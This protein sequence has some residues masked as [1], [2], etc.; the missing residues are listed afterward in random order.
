MACMDSNTRSIVLSLYLPTFFLSFAT[1]LLTPIMPLY[2]RS[3]EI[4][5]ALV[6]VVLAAQGTGNLIG[7]I[8]AGII[9]GKFGHKLTM[10]IGVSMF[11]L[12]I[13]AMS[14]A[15]TVPE[16]ITYGFLAGLGNAMWNISRHAYMTD[17]VPLATRGRVSATF[18]GIN[19]IGT[20]LGPLLGG[21]VAATFGLRVPFLFFGAITVVA[22]VL[23]ALYVNESVAPRKSRGG[24]RGHTI[25]LI[26][27]TRT[28]AGILTTAG[29]A[30][31][32]AQMIRTGR[33]SIIPLYAADVVGLDVQTIGLIV[34]LASAIDMAMFYPAGVIMDRWGRKWA[35]APSFLI[36]GIGMALVPLTMSFETLL[37]ATLVI[38]F[39]NGIGSGTMLTLG[40][41]L[42]P[43]ES[44][45]EF[46]GVW[47]LI[48][49]LGGTGAPLAVGGVA[50]LVGLAMSALVMAG[51]GMGAAAILAFLVPETLRRPAVVE[52]KPAPGD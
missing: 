28:Y 49:D 35:S 40:S 44:M 29:I 8:P 43:K 17:L 18:G 50:D 19:R 31:L 25:H 36:Q 42:A 37:M 10:L 26:E 15:H 52:V 11:G 9:L 46:L 48:G 33:N 24:V 2:A 38:G 3:F 5:Y 4:S 41:D 23:S 51:V 39:G 21:T 27:I 12:C 22:F 6:G 16:L 34:T 14:W 45:G 7:D 32:L 20:F 1:G 30:Q 13:T 47:R